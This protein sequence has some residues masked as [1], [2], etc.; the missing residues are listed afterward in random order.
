MKQR[1]FEI[2]YEN[3]DYI[4]INKK[5]GILSIPDR[6]HDDKINI[7]TLLKQYRDPIFSV[8][9]LDKETSGTM[10]YAKHE[11]AHKYL[12]EQ[13]ES[14]KVAKK[15]LA[16][17]QGNP[18]NDSDEIITNVASSLTQKNKMVVSNK[19]KEAI[20][21]Y[22]VV[23]R[24]K[25]NALLEVSILTGR[26]HQIRVHLS[27]IGHPLA[28]DS[29]YGNKSKLY[30]YEIKQSKYNYSKERDPRPLI[31]RHALHAEKLKFKDKISGESK[32]FIS[33]LPKDMKAVLNQLRKWSSLI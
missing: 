17:V 12:S 28:V 21:R 24:F 16:I 3:D 13:F 30:A 19:G 5:A 20:T 14:R 29:K 18:V 26:Q 23:E 27:Y 1:P 33:P 31:S 6:Y 25:N 10:V 15:Y 8:H 4:V 9:R 32:E 11:E 2:I 7:F 22:N